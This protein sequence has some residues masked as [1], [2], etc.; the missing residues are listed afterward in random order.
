VSSH[1]T[2]IEEADT[3]FGPPDPTPA[4]E[5]AAKA[6]VREEGI[7]D[8]DVLSERLR[9]HPRGLARAALADALDVEEM[10]AKLWGLE[11]RR[12]VGGPPGFPWQAVREPIKSIYR[13][14][15]AYLRVAILGEEGEE[16]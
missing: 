14:Q 12:D 1:D 4:V 10:A 13:E 6:I 15:A 16:G 9:D 8:W 11:Y 3:P 2:E 7:L 5:R